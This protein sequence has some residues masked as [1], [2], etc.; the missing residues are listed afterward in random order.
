MKNLGYVMLSLV[1]YGIG[2]RNVSMRTKDLSDFFIFGTKAAA[3]LFIH[4]DQ[5]AIQKV[6]SAKDRCCSQGLDPAFFIP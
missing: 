2:Q 4:K 3:L 1:I 5:V 6:F